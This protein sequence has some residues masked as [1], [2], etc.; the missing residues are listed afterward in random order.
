MPQRY[1]LLRFGGGSKSYNFPNVESSTPHMG[2]V[3]TSIVKMPGQDG[4]HDNYGVSR[5]PDEVGD[6]P[7]TLN[8]FAENNPNTFAE[9]SQACDDILLMKAWGKRP[10]WIQPLDLRQPRRWASARI[11]NIRISQNARSATEF[12]QP[13]T[14]NFQVNDPRWHS[15]PNQVY[16]GEATFGTVPFTSQAQ[17]YLDDDEVFG[18]AEFALQRCVAQVTDGDE[19]NLIN[20]GTASVPAKVTL[21]PSRPWQLSEGLHFGDEGVMI[22]AYGSSSV[23]R[24][25]V[26]RLN[27]WGD[28][29]EG[30]I[31]DNTLGVNEKIEVDARGYRVTRFLY[32][33]F[34]ESGWPDFVRAAGAGFT[35][36]EPGQNIFRVAGNFDGPFGWLTVEYEDGWY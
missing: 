20:M 28:V 13:V 14:I 19:V 9:I 12:L 11:N 1:N 18:A 2:G 29:A 3:T 23:L 30:F 33:N 16:F 25:G 34:N 31:W 32:P 5:A 27:E 15:R 24:P 36:L 8:L 21:A 26:S 17:V 22:G 4:G 7:V 10:L 35:F 6:I